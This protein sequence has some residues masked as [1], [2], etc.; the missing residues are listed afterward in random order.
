MAGNQSIHNHEEQEIKYNNFSCSSWF[1]SL[2]IFFAYSAIC[3][4][5]HFHSL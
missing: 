2:F 3:A 5:N 4:V 1:K